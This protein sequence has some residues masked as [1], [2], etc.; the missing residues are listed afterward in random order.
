LPS[1]PTDWPPVGNYYAAGGYIGSSYYGK[2]VTAVIG[3]TDS[4][5]YIRNVGV[6]DTEGRY[7]VC[8][9][10]NANRHVFREHFLAG[11][12]AEPVGN[13]TVRS[14]VSDTIMWQNSAQ[15]LKDLSALIDHQ[16]RLF[17]ALGKKLITAGLLTTGE[18]TNT[19]PSLEI[20]ITDER[21]AKQ[22]DLPVLQNAGRGVKIL[23]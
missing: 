14:S 2:G 10:K 23:N 22:S 16:Q 7:D 4:V 21:S 19:R 17:D 6:A 18:W 3:G 12:A 11:L 15:Y 20:R 13:P 9:F 8:G 5:I 1:P